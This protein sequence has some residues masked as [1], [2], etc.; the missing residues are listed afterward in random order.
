MKGRNTKNVFGKGFW[1]RR[2]K[3]T[4]IKSPNKGYTARGRTSVPP[5]ISLGKNGKEVIG[6]LTKN[7]AHNTFSAKLRGLC[8][9]NRIFSRLIL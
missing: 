6:R 9:F 8:A 1:M 7:K 2:G 3:V 5:P 4:R